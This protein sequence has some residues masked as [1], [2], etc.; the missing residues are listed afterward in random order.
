[1]LENKAYPDKFDYKETINP[2]GYKY[3]TIAERYLC[4]TY[5]EWTKESIYKR[6]R[7]ILEFMYNEWGV[8]VLPKDAKKV[9]GL[10]EK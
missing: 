4:E 6:G 3:G 10:P 5:S 1:M 8:K 7:E 2:T 9:L